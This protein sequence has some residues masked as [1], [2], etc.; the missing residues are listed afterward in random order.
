[1]KTIK[2]LVVTAMLITSVSFYGQIQNQFPLNN[3][4]ELKNETKGQDYQAMNIAADDAD[5]WITFNDSNNRWWSMGTDYS[6]DSDFKITYGGNLKGEEPSGDNFFVIRHG[7]NVG[8]GTANPQAK[9]SVNGKVLAEEIE[10]I[11]DVPADYVFED[12][13]DLKSLE[14]VEEY[15]SEN[16]HLPKVPSAEVIK[17]QGWKVG[18][19]SNKLLEKIEELTLYLIE[20]NKELV[21]LKKENLELKGKISQ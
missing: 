10:V 13:Y 18:E 4:V 16:G 20:I 12:T 8:I 15:I 1:M 14:E 17:E 9:L 21:E 11:V 6:M 7:G 3:T 2:N 5:G 19:M